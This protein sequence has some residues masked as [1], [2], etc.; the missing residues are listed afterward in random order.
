MA[1]DL[2]SKK[3]SET[4]KSILKIDTGFNHELTTSPRLISDGVGNDSALSLSLANQTIGA[5]FTG[6][7]GIGTDSPA[8]ELEIKGSNPEIRLVESGASNAYYM[9]ARNDGGFDLVDSTS[10]KTLLYYDTSDNLRFH[11]NDVYIKSDGNVGIGTDAPDT[12]L[13]IVQTGAEYALHV[14]C[15]TN[16]T[17]YG[18][19][20]AITCVDENTTSYPL[21]INTN[22]ADE[23]AGNVRFVV[24]GDGKV[25]IGTAAPAETLTIAH[26]A[27]DGDGGILIFNENTTIADNTFLGGIGFDSADGNVPSSVGE[28]GAA[29]VA[30]SAE[31]HSVDDKGAHLLFLTAPID[32]DDDTTT[33]ERVRITSEGYVGIGNTSPATMLEVTRTTDNE[34]HYAVIR[35]EGDWNDTSVTNGFGGTGG[36]FTA[37]NLDSTANNYSGLYFENAS[38]YGDAGIQ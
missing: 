18:N 38:G 1:Y 4:Y 34:G 21:Y 30:R 16:T 33:P 23:E 10:S 32:Q 22:S 24:R 5:S 9:R 3:P 25:G 28:A 35:S 19:G 36:G 14:A 27:T 11:D 12:Q 7:V 8:S 31:D 15:S 2:T 29:I 13:H 20:I 6:N 17:N 26:S 37:K